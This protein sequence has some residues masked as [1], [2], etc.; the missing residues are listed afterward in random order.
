MLPRILAAFVLAAFVLAAP[1]AVLAQTTSTGR[2][3][4]TL[5]PNV[6]TNPWAKDCLERGDCHLSQIPA[7]ILYVS[8]YLVG[9]A[10]TVTL[11]MVMYGGYLYVLGGVSDANKGKG[12]KAVTTA[13]TGFAITLLA[14]VIVKALEGLLL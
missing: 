8:N 2:G 1:S 10:G 6:S 9:L 5:L 14:Y 12:M 11:V 7:F 4:N 3:A 13:L